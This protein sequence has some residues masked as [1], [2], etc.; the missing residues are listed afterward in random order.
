[1]SMSEGVAPRFRAWHEDHTRWGNMTIIPLP[2]NNLLLDIT[3]R[4]AETS[5]LKFDICNASE[6]LKISKLF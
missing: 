5:I 4:N 2:W 1:M 6:S 3:V